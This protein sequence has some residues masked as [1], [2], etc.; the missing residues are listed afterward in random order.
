MCQD[1]DRKQEVRGTLKIECKT[2]KPKKGRFFKK[3]QAVNSFQRAQ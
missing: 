3:R 2:V 1:R